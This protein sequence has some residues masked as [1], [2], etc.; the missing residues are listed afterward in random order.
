MILIKMI[1]DKRIIAQV[2]SSLFIIGF[3]YKL[4]NLNSIHS[5]EYTSDALFVRSKNADLESWCVLRSITKQ[6][7]K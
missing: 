2:A 7:Y 1:Y 5:Q 6:L 4:W 3:I